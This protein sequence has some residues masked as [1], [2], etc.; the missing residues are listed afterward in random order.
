METSSSSHRW[1]KFMHGSDIKTRLKVFTFFLLIVVLLGYIVYQA[2]YQTRKEWLEKKL[3]R[4]LQNDF[5]RFRLSR[6]PFS[7]RFSEDYVNKVQ[8]GEKICN[9]SRILVIGLVR[10][11]FTRI[12]QNLENF[13]I[14]VLR[15]STKEYHFV[16][17]ENGSTDSSREEMKRW[18]TLNAFQSIH[19]HFTFLFPSGMESTQGLHK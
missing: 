12:L 16:L 11:K 1:Y 4:S 17:L 5:L 10:N 15:N 13:W 18:K 7:S 8:E 14:P 2:F 6:N 3:G 19:K 9:H